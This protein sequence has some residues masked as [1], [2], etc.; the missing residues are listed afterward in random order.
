MRL[1]ALDIGERR[2]GL[3]V[4]ESGLLASP[5]SV[6]ERKSKQED[7][8]R[9]RRLIEELHIERVIVG[10]PYSL[11]DPAEIG[12]QARRVKRYADALAQTLPTPLDY[13]DERYSTVDAAAY[14]ADT[15]PDNERRR[16]SPRRS[17]TPLD[18]AAAAVILQNYLNAQGQG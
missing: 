2:I 14:L 8:A 17:K 12:P 11:S 6:L 4:S 5:H 16:K 1:L 3:A 13:F 15:G 7:F 18:A 9:L 10:L